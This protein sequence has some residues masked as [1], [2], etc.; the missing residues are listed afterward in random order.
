[1]TWKRMCEVIGA[2]AAS[3]ALP[4]AMC[5]SGTAF[6][7]SCIV[8]GTLDR[9]AASSGTAATAAAVGAATAAVS[10]PVAAASAVDTR[11]GTE[12]EADV[13]IAFDSRRPTGL[14]MIIR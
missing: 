13:L 6:A 4:V 1:M 11:T 8:S 2:V 9:A 3:A 14:M 12:D 7:A 10:V 5:I